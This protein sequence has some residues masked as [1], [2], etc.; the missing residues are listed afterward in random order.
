MFGAEVT[1]VSEQETLFT[2]GITLSKYRHAS[3]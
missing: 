3:K 2:A 1:L